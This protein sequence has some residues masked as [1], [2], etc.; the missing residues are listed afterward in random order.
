MA[1][2]QVD[3]VDRLQCRLNPGNG[4]GR[5]RRP[6][7]IVLHR[8]EGRHLHVDE[9]SAL[10][11]RAVH[12]V[13][14]QPQLLRH[15]VGEAGSVHVAPLGLEGAASGTNFVDMEVTTFDPMEHNF[16]GSPLTTN[17]IARIEST[18]EAIDEVSAPSPT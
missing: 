13:R 10:S 15:H 11:L 3:F 5:E 12:L 2:P 8:V 6:R 1:M 9:V 14:M 17:T 7:E 4:I 18:L 16:P